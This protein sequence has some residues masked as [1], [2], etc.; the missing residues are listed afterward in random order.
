MTSEEL[1]KLA[2]MNLK[3]ETFLEK[4]KED[5]ALMIILWKDLKAQPPGDWAYAAI[6]AIKL[7]D[8][9]KVRA[10]YDNLIKNLPPFKIELLK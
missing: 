8:A 6:M 10:E 7:A 1:Q 3:L 5:I 9:F 4:G 2:E